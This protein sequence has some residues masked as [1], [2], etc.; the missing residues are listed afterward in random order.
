MHHAQIALAMAKEWG[1]FKFGAKYGERF[2][3]S[4]I[5]ECQRLK[6]N[7]EI[8]TLYEG[9]SPDGVIRRALVLHERFIA[10]YYI[11][12]SSQIIY[13]TKIIDTMMKTE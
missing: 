4:L 6:A 7:P 5:R 10:I 9:K 8:G 11:D 3:K 13:I 1:K 2:T 12:S